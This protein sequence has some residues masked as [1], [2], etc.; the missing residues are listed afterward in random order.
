MTQT[1]ALTQEERAEIRALAEQC[2]W[3]GERLDVGDVYSAIA[4]TNLDAAAAGI[5]RLLDALEAVERER[6]RLEAQMEEMAEQIY[7]S[8]S[9][10]EVANMV[11]RLEAENS[12]LR[13]A[14]TG[15]ISGVQYEI[16][17]AENARLRMLV[18]GVMDEDRL[19]G[20][21]GCFPDDTLCA[22]NGAWHTETCKEARALTSAGEEPSDG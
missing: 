2:A 7:D 15:A 22:G 9:K 18:S 17:L 8:I 1:A 10:S 16:V 13:A 19:A 21:H 11:E 5:T 14:L 3:A 4:A 12:Q 20:G 6:D